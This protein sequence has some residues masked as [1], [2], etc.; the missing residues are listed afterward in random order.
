MSIRTLAA[1]AAAL[2]FA[3]S[4]GMAN[5]AVLSV[6]CTGTPATSSVT[7]TANVSGG[8][9]PYALLWGNGSTST[10]QVVNE[11]PGTYTMNIQATDA[12]SSVAT[13]SC[14]A[15]VAQPQAAP[16]VASF[17][18]NP[19][20][21]TLGQSTMLTWSVSNASST[22][23]DHGIG[24]VSSSSI[25]VSPTANTTYT[26]TATNPAGT[27][28]AQAT[29]VVNATSTPSSIQ[30]QI[31]ALLQQI[32]QLQQQIR[33]LLAGTAG[34]STPPVIPPGQA[35]K[36]ACIIL[37]RDLR[38]GDNGTDVTQLQQFLSGNGF[39][40]PQTGFFGVLTGRALTRLQ[41]QF[42]IASTSTGIVG[43]RT[44][45]FFE[46]N[47]GQGLGKEKEN[48]EGSATSTSTSTQSNEGNGHGEG[49]GKG[50][51]D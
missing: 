14:S 50:N 9:A 43:P 1:S 7:W 23:L 49:N 31:A 8:V 45:G 17:T 51:D 11:I 27:T 29:V 25:T 26:L 5:A 28:T 15:V 24:V 35:G 22:S 38:E 10:V 48:D 37:N 19:A 20:S 47:C 13:S 32:A 4:I 6:S 33:N 34:T 2:A 36:G 42:G 40:V 21:I 3:L 12:S 30:A 39:S 41:Q 44:R 18:A 46:R 16:T